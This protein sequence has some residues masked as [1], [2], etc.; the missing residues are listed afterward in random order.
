MV[1]IRPAQTLVLGLAA[2]ACLQLFHLIDDLRVDPTATLVSELVKPQAIAGVGGAI[3]ASALIA[4]GHRWG[5][6]L[7]IAEA[8]L[9]ALGFVLV[10]GIPLKTGPIHPYWGPGS[11][12]VIQWLGVVLIWACCA[13]VF[14]TALRLEQREAVT[15]GRSRLTSLG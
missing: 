12:D 1:H 4:T 6:P 9:V 8:T 10:H 5:R 14:A 13:F 2:L 15:S 7:A 11:A 3:L